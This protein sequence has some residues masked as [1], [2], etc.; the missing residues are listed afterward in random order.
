MEVIEIDKNLI[1]YRFKIKFS[2]GIFQLG[3]RY[4]DF[5]DR[6]YIDLFTDT[7]EIIQDNSTLT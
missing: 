5:A 2:N 6:I 4:N 3:I 1:P 7:G